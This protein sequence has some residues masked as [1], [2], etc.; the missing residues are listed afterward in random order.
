MIPLTINYVHT[1]FYILTIVIWSHASKAF[2]HIVVKTG[3]LLQIHLVS[4]IRVVRDELQNFQLLQQDTDNLMDCSIVW[5]LKFNI[6]KCNLELPH[7]CQP[8]GYGKYL[9]DGT[10]T[11]IYHD[12]VV[13]G[14]GKFIDGKLKLIL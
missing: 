2:L 10:T 14:L 7:L 5:Q 8:H 12:N 9:I 1:N 13:K 6:I 11:C 4:Y 3:C